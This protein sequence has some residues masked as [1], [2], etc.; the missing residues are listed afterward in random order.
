MAGKTLLATA[1]GAVTI[2]VWGMLFWG[3]LAPRLGIF[4]ALP[5]SDAV[6]AALAAGGTRTG[7]YFMPWPRD[8]PESSER[9]RAQHRSG[10]FF[11]LSYVAEGVDP[12]GPSKLVLGALHY[13]TVA[14]MGV[15]MALLV[16]GPPRRRFFAVLLAG[17]LGSNFITIGDPVWFHMPW[18]YAR[19]VLLY[20]LVAWTLLATV[21]ARLTVTGVPRAPSPLRRR[22]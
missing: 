13:L 1:A 10:P 15:G 11:R 18:D 2:V 7:T 6:T 16:G 9:F 12:A 21:L 22:A 3:L 5:D 19:G 8:T 20:Q 17:L 14:A 4:H